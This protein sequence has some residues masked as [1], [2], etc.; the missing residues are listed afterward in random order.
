MTIYFTYK[1]HIFSK[2]YYICLPGINLVSF[3]FRFGNI[4]IKEMQIKENIP[5]INLTRVKT[6][7]SL[8]KNNFIRKDQ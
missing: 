5:E 4:H 7:Y 8:I 3:N 1:R 2:M 6:Y